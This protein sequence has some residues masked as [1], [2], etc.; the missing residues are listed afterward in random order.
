M[1]KTEPW[2][3]QQPQGSGVQATPMPVH[4]RENLRDIS[5]HPQFDLP[6]RFKGLLRHLTSCQ[7][8]LLWRIGVLN[9]NLKTEY[10]VDLSKALKAFF[11]E[12]S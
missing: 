9:F 7:I 12:F 10:F 2:S 6:R 8:E 3:T 11:L 4:F 1:T 5:H